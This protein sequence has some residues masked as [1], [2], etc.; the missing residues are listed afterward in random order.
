[1]PKATNIVNLRL[2]DEDYALV[3]KLS[4]HMDRAIP[5]TMRRVIR[6]AAAE[7]E[8]QQATE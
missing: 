4:K 1:M 3:V 6:K 2:H 7:L 5:D 8:Q